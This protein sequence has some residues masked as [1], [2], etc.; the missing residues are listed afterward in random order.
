[1][2]ILLTTLQKQGIISEYSEQLYFNKLNKLDKIGKFLE[3]QELPRLNYK[4]IDN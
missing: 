3:T 1:M 2:E 4:E